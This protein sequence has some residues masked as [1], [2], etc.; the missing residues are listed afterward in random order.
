VVAKSYSRNLVVAENADAFGHS[1]EEEDISMA[2][3][4]I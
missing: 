4:V 2:S 3:H 1:E